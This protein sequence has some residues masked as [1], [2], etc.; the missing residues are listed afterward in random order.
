MT[1][2]VLLNNR[3]L[4]EGHNLILFLNG[5]RYFVASLL[6]RFPLLILSL[7]PHVHLYASPIL[8]SMIVTLHDEQIK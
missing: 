3:K 8:K 5:P 4:H 1:D 7:L 6:S 2:L